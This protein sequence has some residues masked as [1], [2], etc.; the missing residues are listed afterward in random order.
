[1]LGWLCLR[2]AVVNAISVQNEVLGH[3]LQR[4]VAP[5]GAPELVAGGRLG[6]GAL[7]GDSA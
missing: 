2:A 4:T 6:H 3:K 7:A 1:M 5:V